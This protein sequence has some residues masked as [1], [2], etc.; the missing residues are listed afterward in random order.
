MA[1]NLYVRAWSNSVLNK[2]LWNILDAH[3]ALQSF[4]IVFFTACFFSCFLFNFP[5]LVL[6]KWVIVYLCEYLNQAVQ[7]PER[8]ASL[9][10]TLSIWPACP[11]HTEGP[12]Q[13]VCQ[14]V[15]CWSSALAA[16]QH[17]NMILWCSGWA[18]SS[19]WHGQTRFTRAETNSTYLQTQIIS[20][21]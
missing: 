2:L 1:H 14:S 4:R 12:V 13:P 11:V 18:S 17:G 21:M 3:P 19:W 10:W 7:T 5:L 20:I 9:C 8:L 15:Y 6:S 16:L